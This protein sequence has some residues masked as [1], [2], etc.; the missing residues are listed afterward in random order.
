MRNASSVPVYNR[1]V[2]NIVS[3]NKVRTTDLLDNYEPIEDYLDAARE[4]ILDHESSI[5]G[6]ERATGI[7]QFDDAL[8]TTGTNTITIGAGAV[9][10]VVIDE[11]TGDY[12]EQTGW[13][14]SGAIDVSSYTEGVIWVRF[15]G[16]IYTATDKN[17]ANRPGNDYYRVL[18][19]TNNAGTVIANKKSW[20]K[21]PESD[22][23][24]FE[25]N[26]EFND[27]VIFR[28]STTFDNNS[29]LRTKSQPVGPGFVIN[30]INN[31]EALDD[32]EG[33]STYADAAA[34]TPVDGTGGSANITFIR[35]TSTVLR[36]GASFEIQKDTVN[37]QGEGVSCDFSV[38][39]IDRDSLLEISFEHYNTLQFSTGDIRVYI[40]D[41]VNLTLI[42]PS[43]VN[44]VDRG[45]G[46]PSKYSAVF[47][48]SSN[49]VLYRLIFHI[50]STSVSAY[51]FTWDNVSVSPLQKGRKYLLEEIVLDGAVARQDILS[52]RYPEFKV[53]TVEFVDLQPTVND[54]EFRLRTSRDEGVSFDAGGSDYKH[55]ANNTYTSS[56]T[57]GND[58]AI[59]LTAGASGQ[60]VS[61]VADTSLQGSVVIHN[62]G[63]TSL[64]TL[65][66]QNIT[67][68]TGGY[69]PWNQTGAGVR[70]F[71]GV[72]NAATFFFNTGNIANGTFYV[73]GTL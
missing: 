5:A 14:D 57:G 51:S 72:V 31:N 12:T 55:W 19:F 43:Q 7:R 52:I 59:R 24:R 36:N 53:Y 18:T 64:R 3:G 17:P 46:V 13:A 40:F 45:S 34:I 21:L 58:N 47:K 38:D 11:V 10:L 23:H 44:V 69:E 67:Y 33:W 29:S 48:T 4:F 62:P 61:N 27:D 22:T 1:S 66:T 30:H 73:Y 42:S 2:A 56:V 41:R 70:Q 39:L 8:V 32:L 15:T 35:D 6:I 20:Q 71:A 50:A 65:V 49:S 63:N 28:G 25:N 37:R 16:L 26:V 9:T 68:L 60:R 54:V